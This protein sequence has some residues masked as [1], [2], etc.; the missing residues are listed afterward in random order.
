MQGGGAMAGNR[1]A[2]VVQLMTRCDDG[3]AMAGYCAARVIQL[4]ACDGGNATARLRHRTALMRERRTVDLQLPSGRGGRIERRVGGCEVQRAITGD[5]AACSTQRIGVKAQ[6]ACASVF[7]CPVGVGQRIGED[8]YIG[9]VSRNTTLGVIEAA[10]QIERQFAAACLNDLTLT[11]REV[12]GGR[13]DLIGRNISPVR[14]QRL[15]CHD[16]ECLTGGDRGVGQVDLTAVGRMGCVVVTT[17]ARSEGEVAGT[18]LA[19]RGA[20]C[21]IGLNARSEGE[22]TCTSLAARQ[23]H[24]LCRKTLITAA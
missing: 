16:V 4:V 14:A 3:R 2:G 7:E 1:A 19:A 13:I 8:V 9:T 23:I 17:T 20:Q 5:R 22:I 6:G 10:W 18:G 15:R 12:V 24:R 11:I 21:A